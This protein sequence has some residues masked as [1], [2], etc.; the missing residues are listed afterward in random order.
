M[1]F[2]V[3]PAALALI[4]ALA[5]GACSSE[6]RGTSMAERLLDSYKAQ[7]AAKR[8]KDQVPAAARL[9][10]AQIDAAKTPIVRLTL[11]SSGTIATAGLAEVNRGTQT[12]LMATGQAV[13]L[14]GGFLTGTRGLG[15]D[16]MSAAVPGSV[17]AAVRAGSYTRVHRTLTADNQLVAASYACTMRLGGPTSLDQLGR[18]YAVRM[19]TET[20]TGETGSFTNSYA[21]GSGG[22][23]W[24][25][26]QW[27]GPVAGSILVEQLK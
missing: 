1:T 17:A 19:A 16:L 24:Q 11:K 26:T 4:A 2:G 12:Y 20:C 25:S 6:D 7:R 18:R 5:L 27:I 15:H 21:L 3:K 8:T 22:Q 23:V 14:R 13:Y 9:T 10:R